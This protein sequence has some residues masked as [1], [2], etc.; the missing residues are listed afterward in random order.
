MKDKTQVYKTLEKYLNKC[1]AGRSA[2][3]HLQ[4]KR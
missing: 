2:A 3:K 1:G 4:W